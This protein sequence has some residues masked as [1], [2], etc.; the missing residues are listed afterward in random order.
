VDVRVIAA[1]HVDVQGAVDGGRF[2]ADLFYRLSVVTLTLPPLRDRKDDLALLAAHFLRKHGGE[3]PPRLTSAAF[4]ALMSYSW[5]GNV[6]ELENAIL[7]AVALRH[8]DAIDV[9]ALPR[10]IV[11]AA[12]PSAN[13][14]VVP[15]T[16]QALAEAKRRAMI[17][18][19]RAYLERVLDLTKGNVAEAARRTGVD[20]SNFRRLLHRH[21]IDPES[22]RETGGAP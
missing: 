7:G 22:Y 21:G 1:T 17:D 5:P 16:E 8:G 12:R 14:A 20:R 13:A 9:A 10:R 19:E 6:R 18:F 11:E 4:E 15:D 3:P 2:R